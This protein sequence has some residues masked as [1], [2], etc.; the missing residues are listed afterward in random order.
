MTGF[1]TP[2]LATL[3]TA[4]FL[5]AGLLW[6]GFLGSRQLTG[7][8]SDLDAIEYLTLDWRLVLAGARP[9]PGLVAIAA[10]DE[11]TIQTA[12]SYPLPRSAI[13]KIVRAI[14]E[15]HPRAIAIDI[16]FLDAG[17]PTGDTQLAEALRASKSVIAAIG[18]FDR[19]VVDGSTKGA[20][21]DPSSVL[22][23]QLKFRVSARSGLVNISTD[24]RGIPR[25]IPLIYHLGDTVVPSL[26]LVTAS[27][28][29]DADPL[30]GAQTVKLGEHASFTDFGDH[31]PLH[32]YGPHGSF[33]Q[34]SAGQALD[35]SLDE[36]SV[37]GRVV[38][39][40]ATAL[41]V[42]DSF[43]TPFDR[44]VPGVEVFATGISNL[45]AGDGLIRTTYVRDVDAAAAVLLPCSCVLLMAMRRSFAGVLLAGLLLAMWCV[46]TFAVLAVGYWLSAA[47]P[48]A[49]A[50]PVAIGYGAARL[51]LDQI[52]AR[53]LT[54]DVALLARFQSP[55]LVQQ[56]LGTPDFLERPVH[57]DVG[58]IFVDLSSF[59]TAAETF[60][61]A[62]ARDLLVQFHALIER[63]AA[64]RGG[65][66]A[67]FMGD[68]AMVVFGLPEARADDA[69]RTLDAV[70]G[71]QFSTAAWLA[72]VPNQP[73]SGMRVRI[74]AHYGP[75]VLSRLGPVHHQHIAATGDTVNVAARLME[76]AKQQNCGV[77]VSEALS[78][79]ADPSRTGREWGGGRR[80]DVKI[81]GR[82]QPLG[83]WTQQ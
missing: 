8:G 44:I 32:Y 72:G 33:R 41:G 55:L 3:L 56:I 45:L 61:A 71:V 49:A 70:K 63:E 78:V 60:G 53:R 75:V 13:A 21:A 22:W 15:R 37:R 54:R 69:A 67:S 12:G 77:V 4:I 52:V 6:G 47:V 36:A 20:S 5:L 59:T 64:A 23:P 28:A 14:E 83:V 24:A 31:L 76:V 51:G 79:A 68:G 10:I 25:F 17:E 82:S 57:R 9:E 18:Q 74:G 62:W 16:A 39:L 58:V 50:V 29:L 1:R 11:E 65:F 26:A 80:L 35:G 34:F 42:G 73:A 7:T 40:G 2:S 48:L 66:V 27:V 46:L 43:A 19:A 81:R 30:F 38:V